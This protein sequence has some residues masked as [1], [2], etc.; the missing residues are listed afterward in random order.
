MK[1]IILI[2]FIL[3]NASKACAISSESYAWST[4]T[5]EKDFYHDKFI[6]YFE[7]HPRTQIDFIDLH[8]LVIRPALGYRANKNT[9]LW[10][11]YAW[12]P[13]FD[14][15]KQESRIW[16]SIEFKNKYKKLDIDNRTRLE[17]RF[18]ED[19]SDM[20]LR[21]RHRLKFAYPIVQDESLKVVLSEELFIYLNDT[22]NKQPGFDQNRLFIGLNKKLNEAVSLE[23]GYMF[24]YSL[25]QGEDA[26][27]H[28]LIL[29][30]NINL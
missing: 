10:L 28:N 6:A 30:L 13:I 21:L 17:E 8:R 27:N 12:T 15:F 14:P 29:N 25:K 4:I 18:I 19:S 5:V 11:G 26:I 23:G 22:T 24:R 9:V 3:F 7:I 1:K 16:Q 20:S 2:I